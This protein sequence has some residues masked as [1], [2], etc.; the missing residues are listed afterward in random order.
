MA[1]RP[2]QPLMF[3]K[4]RGTHPLTGLLCEAFSNTWYEQVKWDGSGSAMG[5]AMGVNLV[6]NIFWLGQPMSNPP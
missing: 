5:M 2:I 3:L 4:T 6:A 1:V